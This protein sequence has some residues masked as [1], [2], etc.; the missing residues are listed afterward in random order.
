MDVNKITD[1]IDIVGNTLTKEYFG[2]PFQN[3]VTGEANDVMYKYN[4]SRITKGSSLFEVY[5]KERLETKK[6]D[7]M[8]KIS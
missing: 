2:K 5:K 1:F 7:L 6:V 4:L 8:D 3:L